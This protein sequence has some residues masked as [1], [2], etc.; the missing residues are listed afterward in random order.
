VAWGYRVF[1]ANK[2][3]IAVADNATDISSALAVDTA[4]K[5]WAAVHGTDI[6]LEAMIVQAITDEVKLRGLA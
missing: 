4:A 3:A 5:V 2:V 1:L 6:D